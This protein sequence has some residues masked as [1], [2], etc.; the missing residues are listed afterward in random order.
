M[1]CTLRL[2]TE[3][4]AVNVAAALLVVVAFSGATW[5][6]PWRQVCLEFAA[7]FVVS[8]C[9]ST[10]CIVGIPFV[11]ARLARRFAFPFKWA[12]LIA[13]MLAFAAVGSFVALGVLGAAGVLNLRH[14]ASVWLSGSLKISIIV[15]LIFGV[16]LTAVEMLRGRLDQ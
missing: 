11:D 6:T 16:S 15:T 9:I 7:A 1:R 4:A 12:I 13:A 14:V 3:W 8:A 10:L 2:L 5:R